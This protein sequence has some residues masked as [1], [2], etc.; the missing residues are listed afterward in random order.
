MSSIWKRTQE[1]NE[2]GNSSTSKMPGQKWRADSLAS[3]PKEVWETFLNELSEQEICALPYLFDFWALPHQRPPEGKWRSWLVLGGRGAGKTRAGA[4]WV[5]SQ[6]EGARPFD[7]G[8]ASRIAL[9]R[10]L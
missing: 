4:E 5:R 3:M 8:K 7:K 2:P 1:V 6:V 9:L 10:D